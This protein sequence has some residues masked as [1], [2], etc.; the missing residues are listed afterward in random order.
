MTEKTTEV[1]VFVR[2][3]EGLGGGW[4]VGG[5]GGDGDGGGGG[6]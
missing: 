4:T 1:L 3:L 5:R 6:G 2:R